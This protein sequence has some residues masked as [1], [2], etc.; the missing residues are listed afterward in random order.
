MTSLGRLAD[1]EAVPPLAALLASE[2]AELCEVAIVALGRIGNQSAATALQEFAPRT[3]AALR[4]AVIDAQLAAAESLCRRGEY[5]AASAICE[6]LQ[7]AD[8]ELVRAAAFRGLLAARPAESLTLI[9]A[10]LTAEESWKRA[11]AADCL[12]QVQQPAELAKLPLPLPTFRRQ[13]RSPP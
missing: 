1:A 4:P 12:S 11:V 8:S 6:S 13:A 5:A 2:N 9:L 10:G 7:T 3:P